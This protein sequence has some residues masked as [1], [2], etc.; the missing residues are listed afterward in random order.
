MCQ[1][2]GR[3]LLSVVCSEVPVRTGYLP[4][5]SFLATSLS[6]SCAHLCK[7]CDCC[8]NGDLINWQGCFTVQ[9]KHI[10]ALEGEVEIWPSQNWRAV[11]PHFFFSSHS[12]LLAFGESGVREQCFRSVSTWCNHLACGNKVGPAVLFL[13]CIPT[14]L[15]GGEQVGHRA[16]LTPHS[17][18]QWHFPSVVVG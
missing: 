18:C 14:E 6:N 1:H 10:Q 4:V 9:T 8:S 11:L 13:P 7:N 2:R 5:K 3:L 15:Q 12:F 16:Q 17:S